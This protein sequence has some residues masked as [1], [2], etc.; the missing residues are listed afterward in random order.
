ML[1]TPEHE[2]QKH[3]QAITVDKAWKRQCVINSIREKIKWYLPFLAQLADGIISDMIKSGVEGFKTIEEAKETT[4]FRMTTAMPDGRGV[5]VLTG[6]I[7]SGHYTIYIAREYSDGTCDDLTDM[8]LSM[9]LA[10]IINSHLGMMTFVLN[11][12]IPKLE[13]SVQDAFSPHMDILL[14]D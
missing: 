1:E 12:M 13:R 11:E 2:N 4:R 8:T 14:E 6:H 3:P 7:F 10:L 5:I 9:E